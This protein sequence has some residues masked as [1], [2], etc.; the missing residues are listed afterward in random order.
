M[1]I[2]F[3]IA[4]RQLPPAPTGRSSGEAS[5]HQ[6]P[7]AGVGKVGELVGG[8]RGEA[9]TRRE[10]L[11][12]GRG[13]AGACLRKGVRAG[14]GGGRSPTLEECRSSRLCSSSYV[15][16][17]RAPPPPR[18]EPHLRR[19]ST[20]GKEAS[21]S[22]QAAEKSMH[23]GSGWRSTRRSSELAV[24]QLAG[25]HLRRGKKRP[26]SSSS[27]CASSVSVRRRSTH[28]SP[29]HPVPDGALRLWPADGGGVGRGR[30]GGEAVGGGEAGVVVGAQRD[31]ERRESPRGCVCRGGCRC[32]MQRPLRQLLEAE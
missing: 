11:V 5:L 27:I 19:E 15:A 13:C 16:A 26:W 1:R 24:R 30:R 14:S 23:A 17:N 8:A 12:G 32:K 31:E 2:P 7:S 20:M 6:R 4:P 21:R 25:L 3:C 18:I 22:S 28:L 29:P 10:K 9:P